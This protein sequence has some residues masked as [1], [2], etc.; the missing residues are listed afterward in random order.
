MKC[1]KCKK[2]MKKVK[3]KIQDAKSLATSYQCECGYFDFESESMD[4]VI[5]EIRLREEPLTLQQNVIKLSQGRLGM[6]FN[7]D[8]VRSLRLNGGEKITVS[9]PDKKHIVLSFS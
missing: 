9:V 8:V 6:Y 4:K 3:V 7:K 2:N 5:N 1:P